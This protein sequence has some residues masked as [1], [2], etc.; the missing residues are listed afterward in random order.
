MKKK[1]LLITIM[2]ALVFTL[3]G[4]F[5]NSEEEKNDNA[6]KFKQDYEE[7]NGT[8][9]AK[10]KKHRTITIDSNNRFIEISAEEVVQMIKDKRFSIG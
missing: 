7:I 5:D 2:L 8:E 9:N 3:T 4:C 1:I 10:G 6:L